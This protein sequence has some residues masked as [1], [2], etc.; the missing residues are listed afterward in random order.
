MS[1]CL[2]CVGDCGTVV[3]EP[4]VGHAPAVVSDRGHLASSLTAASK[5]TIAGLGESNIK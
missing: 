4:R 2:A 1:E 3:A 5:S